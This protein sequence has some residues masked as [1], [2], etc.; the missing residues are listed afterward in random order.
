MPALRTLFAAAFLLPLLT[1]AAF[2]TSGWG[3]YRVN[4][5]PRDALNIRTGPSARSTAFA[6]YHWSDQPIIALS[7]GLTR[8]EGVQPDLFDV[9]RAEFEVC[10][11]GN[12]PIGARWCPVTIF[13]GGGSRSGWLKRRF[14]DHSECP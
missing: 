3:C 2:A 5:G 1:E 11:P 13:D 14:V 6:T 12:L 8:G 10:V 9:H 4:V 7:G